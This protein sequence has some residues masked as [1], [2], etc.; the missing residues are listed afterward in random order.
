MLPRE[1]GGDLRHVGASARDA[2]HEQ[3][4]SFGARFD[5]GQLQLLH[6]ADDVLRDDVTAQAV[7]AQVAE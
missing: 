5:D 4:N 6:A 2:L 7:L 1:P 3:R